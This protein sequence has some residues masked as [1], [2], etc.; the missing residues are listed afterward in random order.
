MLL[1]FYYHWKLISPDYIL[2]VRGHL[3]VLRGHFC[4][5]WTSFAAED[6][7]LKNIRSKNKHPPP[8]AWH[9]AD[10]ENQKQ[11]V[12]E[13]KVENIKE[14]NFGSGSVCAHRSR[15]GG[16]ITDPSQQGAHWSLSKYQSSEERTGFCHVLYILKSVYLELPLTSARRIQAKIA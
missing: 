6:S 3:T 12:K 1:F 16:L 14:V 9:L 5:H 8:Q 2:L 11:R 10:P 15:W 7:T 13:R 4:E